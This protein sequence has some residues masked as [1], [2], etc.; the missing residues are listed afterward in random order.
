MS[1]LF[2]SVFYDHDLRF[3]A[4]ALGICALGSLTAVAIAQ[5]ALKSVAIRTRLG[6]LLLA[7]LVTGLGVWTTHFTAMLGYRNDLDI[8]FDLVAASVSIVLSA[9]IAMAGWVL[10]FLNR[11]RGILAGAIV[12]ASIVVAHF[13]DMAA[14]R[15]SGVISH[16]HL[17]SLVAIALGVALA[18]TAGHL[19]VR[20]K[21]EV[22]AW[23]AT[24]ALFLAVI[25][26]HFVAMSGITLVP[27]DVP[28]DETVL[29]A[30]SDDLAGIVIGAFLVLLLAAI[31]FALHWISLA[32]A[33]AEEQSRLIK[34]LEELRRSKDH[35]RAYVEL[36]PQIAWVADPQGQVTEIAP[37]WEKLVG[38][39]REE[40]IGA[41]WAKVLHPD[42][43]AAAHEMW[44]K[45]YRTGDPDRA[46][47][48][49]RMRMVDGS[50][51]WFRARARP[52]RDEDGTIL[53][54]YGSLEDIHDQV[55]AETALRE[56]EERYRLAT[57]ATNDVIWDWSF[58]DEQAAWAGAYEKVLGYP[59]L[60]HK[61]ELDWWLDRIHPDDLPRVLANQQMVF[62]DDVDH[63]SEEYR[64][65]KANGDWIDVKSRSIIVRNEA[66]E[67][68]RLVGSM[69]DITQQKK[70]EAELNWAAYHDPLTKLPN[71]A[72]YRIRMCSAIDAARRNN[73]CVALIVLDLNGFKQLNDTLG[74]A[75]GDRVL[76][77]ISR[78]LADSLPE[79]ATVARLG[80]DEFAVILPGLATPEAY[81]L[82]IQRLSDSL[83]EPV[84]FEDQRIP[85]S[86][87]VG[88]AVWP[89]DGEDAA[90]LLISADLALYAAKEEMPGSI[91]EFSPSLRD[92][93]ERRS[94]MLAMARAGLKEDHIVPFYQPKIDLRSGRIMGFEALLRLE[95]ADG[96][97]L[98]PAEIE[99]AFVDA[100]ITVQLT[101]RMFSRVFADLAGWR[102]AGVD[103]G[104]IAINVA[105]GD[106]RRRD[107]AERLDSCAQAY[108]LTL[109]DID[110]EVTENVLIGRLGAEVSRMLQELRAL[111]VMVALDDFGTGYAS[112]THL[113]QYPV[114]VIKIDR[115]FIDRI[116]LKDPKAT[117]VIDAV[118]QMARRLGMQTVAEGIETMQQ[119]RYLRVRGC[120]IGQGYYFS[121]PV[122]AAEVATMLATQNYDRWDF[123]L[124]RTV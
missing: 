49:Y 14:I 66:G 42:D 52:R 86:Y 18:A 38:V 5:H 37:L 80:G 100:V 11:E 6:W 41:G 26:L 97:F 101:N 98:K 84:A 87:G 9:A 48:R 1:D 61:T 54:W 71:R 118:L 77:E 12:G 85:I 123:T 50:Y 91:H 65:L 30:T 68:T 81:R 116:D 60:K 122:P 63:M 88:V 25:V 105:G 28:L 43:L 46:D 53:A 8:R 104:R 39:P 114:D 44:Q 13:V 103:P 74:H 69:L 89:R 17:V 40:G 115:S 94:K 16:D 93:S 107:L 34:A 23:P 59:E 32:Y 99:A 58:T 45:A 96:H 83:V 35:H 106:F 78:R 117:A 55:L 51:R 3:V 72:L 64:F 33:T 110:I 29:T 10:G 75:A 112:L 4:L 124:A 108:R 113:Q 47:T 62:A 67:A 22:F 19:F 27:D 73:D 36:S 95:G 2:G 15:F 24:A 56:S 31:T 111:G 57:R 20:W 90:R 109:A 7:G 121:R 70:A 102:A 82:P 119:A 76:E 120:T 79:G 92:A 21:D